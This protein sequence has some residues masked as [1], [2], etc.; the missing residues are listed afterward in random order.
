M[1]LF[2]EWKQDVKYI[3][4]EYNYYIEPR[5]KIIDF[6]IIKKSDLPYCSSDGFYARESQGIMF[7]YYDLNLFYSKYNQLKFESNLQW[8]IKSHPYDHYDSIIKDVFEY[9]KQ[10]YIKKLRK[11]KINNL[12]YDKI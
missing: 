12:Y 8:Q 5:W 9:N 4:F 10:E 6:K 1:S 3:Y 7:N 11:R 2:E